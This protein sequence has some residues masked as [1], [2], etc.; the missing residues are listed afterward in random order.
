VVDTVVRCSLKRLSGQLRSRGSGELYHGV[1]I[2]LGSKFY[3]LLIKIEME[4][5]VTCQL[6]P[7]ITSVFSWKN[8]P[9]GC[10]GFGRSYC[11]LNT[12]LFSSC[13]F[14]GVSFVGVSSAGR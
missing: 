11:F 10:A 2:T 3:F 4:F 8:P 7:K 5:E 6:N 1:F 13:T 9:Q 12:H 14:F